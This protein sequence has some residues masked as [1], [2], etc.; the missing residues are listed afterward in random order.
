MTRKY[1]EENVCILD[2]FPDRNRLGIAKAS[3]TEVIRPAKG[4][5]KGYFQKL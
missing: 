4:I 1:L 3:L 2:G 5:K